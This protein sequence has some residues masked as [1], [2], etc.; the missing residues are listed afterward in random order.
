[1]TNPGDIYIAT[2]LQKL[3][4]GEGDYTGLQIPS[5]LTVMH[6]KEVIDIIRNSTPNVVPTEDG[7]ISF[8]WL[9]KGWTIYLDV[10]EHDVTIQAEKLNA[11]EK[12]E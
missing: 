12:E 11:T 7:E 2:R 8:I 6:A 9:I 5:A 10:F 4:N 1:M 3:A